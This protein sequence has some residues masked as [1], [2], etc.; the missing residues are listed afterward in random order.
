LQKRSA[1]KKNLSLVFIDPH[2]DVAKEIR[3]FYANDDNNRVV[4][5][6]PFLDS[7]Y[8]PVINPFQIEKTDEHSIDITTQYLVAVFKELLPSA[9]FS[10]NMEAV[11]YPC[12]SVLLKK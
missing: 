8:T 4:Y 7:E 2:G 5:I 3:N 12:I 6:D 11:L 9:Q 10:H 1:K